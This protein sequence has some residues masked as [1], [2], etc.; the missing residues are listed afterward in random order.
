MFFLLR[1]LETKGRIRQDHIYGDYGEFVVI[2]AND[3]DEMISKAHKIGIIGKQIKFSHPEAFNCLDDV[4]LFDELKTKHDSIAVVH[5][6][7]K[8]SIFKIIN[9]HISDLNE[10]D[11]PEK[12]RNNRSSEK[13]RTPKENFQDK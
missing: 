13:Q 2:E 1:Q 6:N 12:K 3:E 7:K 4:R 8:K 5:K 9:G 10:T 11:K